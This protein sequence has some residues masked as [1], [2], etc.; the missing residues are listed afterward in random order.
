MKVEAYVFEEEEKV[1]IVR[2]DQ[3][4]DVINQMGEEFD[5]SSDV[6]ISEDDPRLTEVVV[7][8]NPHADA[9]ALITTISIC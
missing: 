9:Y 6:L 5:P 7:E 2:E 4:E 8:M 3:P 1:L